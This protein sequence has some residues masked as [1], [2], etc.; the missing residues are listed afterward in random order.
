ML[1]LRAFWPLVG[2]TGGLGCGK[3]MDSLEFLLRAVLVCLPST[4]PPDLNVGHFNVC[5]P[6]SYSVQCCL[7]HSQWNC[8]G[9]STGRYFHVAFCTVSVSR[10]R[11]DFKAISPICNCWI[12]HALRLEH[13]GAIRFP[14]HHTVV[15]GKEK[16]TQLSTLVTALIVVGADNYT[17]AAKLFIDMLSFI[18]DWWLHCS[19]T[20]TKLQSKTTG[21]RSEYILHA[22]PVEIPPGMSLEN[23]RFRSQKNETSLVVVAHE[24]RL[25]VSDERT[26]ILGL[27][28]FPSTWCLCSVSHF[29]CISSYWPQFLLRTLVYSGV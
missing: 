29:H 5:I 4:N 11:C 18:V 25:V 9:F 10:S 24:H 27:D 21:V 22:L 13:G 2:R 15:F 19:P 3:R 16:T 26:H 20:A 8:D 17:M 28:S 1:C 12:G 14:V 23:N 7:H 6:E